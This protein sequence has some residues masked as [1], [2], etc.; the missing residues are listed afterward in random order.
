MV[1]FNPPARSLLR[2]YLSSR[3]PTVWCKAVPF[4]VM[5]SR[6]TGECGICV[7]SLVRRQVFCDMH[8]RQRPTKG[9]PDLG[10]ASVVW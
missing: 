4:P 6:T 10:A 5:L 2:L 1:T 3:A 7:G 8:A 9:W